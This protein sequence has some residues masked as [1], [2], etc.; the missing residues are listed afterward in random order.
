VSTPEGTP[1]SNLD[2]ELLSAQLRRQSEDLTL[3][4]GL[5]LG[6][7]SAALPPHLVRVRHEGKWK[8]KLAGREPAVLGVSVLLGNHRYDL[9]RADFSAHPVA[10]VIHESGGVAMSTKVVSADE[11]SRQLAADLLTVAQ[12]DAAAVAA[13]QRLTAL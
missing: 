6:V 5:M 10:K 8:A 11:W 12:H 7:L 9:D 1:R 2:L 13:L 3:Y 4:A